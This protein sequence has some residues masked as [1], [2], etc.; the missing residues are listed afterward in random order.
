MVSILQFCTNMKPFGRGQAY[1][2]N[3][4]HYVHHN[5]VS[6]TFSGHENSIPNVASSCYPTTLGPPEMHSEE[7]DHVK[8]ML[9][10]EDLK[11][12]CKMIV[13]KIRVHFLARYC[14]LQS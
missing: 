14:S 4:A 3:L 11:S 12:E 6:L 13:R 5:M 2:K 1:E 8:R 9:T 7:Q 10:D